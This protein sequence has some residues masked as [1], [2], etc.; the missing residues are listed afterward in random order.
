[1]EFFAQSP[2]ELLELAAE[3]HEEYARAQLYPHIVLDDFFDPDA[4]RLVAK[5]FP[6]LSGA[7][8]QQMK[9]KKQ[10]KRAS[11]G[12]LLLRG[13]MR[14][15]LRTLNSEPMI[16]FLAAP[17][18]IEE[19]LIPDPHFDGGGCHEIVPGGM[20]KLHADFTEH[21]TNGLDRRLNL[22][23]YLNEDWSEEYGGCLELWDPDLKECRK[24]V[25]PVFNRMC[26]FSTTS[27]SFHG[28]PEPLTCPPD[29]SRRFAREWLPPANHQAWRRPWDRKLVGMS[30]LT[31]PWIKA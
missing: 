17:T 22:L 23:V 21:P 5:E 25:L 18:G 1:M 2:E 29:R 30:A 10:I 11:E 13:A 6:D 27:S 7:G 12:E 8:A 28:H 14:D 31:I 24:K 16:D 26:V 4:L 19:P 3:H 20:L 15:F 9:G